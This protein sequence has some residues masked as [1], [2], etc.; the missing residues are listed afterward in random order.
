LFTGSLYGL[1]LPTSAHQVTVLVTGRGAFVCV[2]QLD[3]REGTVVACKHRPGL[4][5]LGL[6]RS[7]QAQGRFVHFS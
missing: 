2:D 5:S 6:D 3:G 1:P 7:V 4:P